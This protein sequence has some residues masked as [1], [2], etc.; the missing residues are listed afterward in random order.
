[1]VVESVEK[2]AEGALMVL[3]GFANGA[4]E[5]S[6]FSVKVGGDASGALSVAAGQSVEVVAETVGSAIMASGK[7]I[8]FIPNVMGQSLMHHSSL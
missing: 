1:M 2:T 4:S 8:A 7:V 6:K 5:A 3:R